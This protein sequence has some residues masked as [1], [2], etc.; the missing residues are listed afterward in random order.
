MPSFRRSFSPIHAML[1]TVVGLLMVVGFGTC[2]ILFRSHNDLTGAEIM[3]M[4]GVLLL[5]TAAE[6]ILGA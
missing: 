6:A 4:I 5:F 2:L 3:D 1:C